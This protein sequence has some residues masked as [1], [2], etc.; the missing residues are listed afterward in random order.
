MSWIK[1]IGYAPSTGR[2]R[3]VY[4][5]I[6]GPGNAIDNILQV[7]SLRPHTLQGHM[8]LYK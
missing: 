5:R 8:T 3:A 1:V 4:E 2:L 7:Q 6:G